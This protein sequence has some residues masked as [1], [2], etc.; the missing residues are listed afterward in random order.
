MEKLEVTREVTILHYVKFE[1]YDISRINLLKIDTE[2]NELKVLAGG[3]KTLSANKIDIIQ[4]EFN[5]MNVVSRTF[6]RDFV[7]LLSSY[8]M[9][10]LLPKSFLPIKYQRPVKHEIFAFQNIIA[11]RKEIDKTE[12]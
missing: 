8:N 4:I 7:Q 9:Y 3:K 6:M 2:G 12:F 10:R 5:E 11:I 1:E